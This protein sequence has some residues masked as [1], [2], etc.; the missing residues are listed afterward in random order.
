MVQ[1]KISPSFRFENFNLTQAGTTL[2][3]LDSTKYY[4]YTE[5]VCED[6]NV[7]IT[8]MHNVF[9]SNSSGKMKNC[10]GGYLVFDNHGTNKN[11]EVFA[12]LEYLV[13]YSKIFEWLQVVF[14]KAG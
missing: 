7:N 5:P 11:W 9:N 10:K 2:Y 4:L 13:I 6:T 1:A 3:N 12:Y 8:V 14:L